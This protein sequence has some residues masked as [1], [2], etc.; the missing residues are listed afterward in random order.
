M[1]SA[2]R[3]LRCQFQ[4]QLAAE[5]E[6]LEQLVLADIGRD[7]LLDLAIVQQHPQAQPVGAAIVGD[8]GDVPDAI[9]L[10]RR[11]QVLR[12]A[13]QAEAAAH[14][15]HAVEGEALQGRG[16]IGIDF[17][18]GQEL[19]PLLVGFYSHCNIAAGKAPPVLLANPRASQLVSH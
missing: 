17:A 2:E 16:G 10:Q 18:L 1:R 4:F 12:I 15:G 6:F 14:H 3:A 9:V 13:G 11:D 7:H 8:D 5:I 19:R